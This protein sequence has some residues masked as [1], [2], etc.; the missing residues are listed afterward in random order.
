[1]RD[2]REAGRQ[3][4]SVGFRVKTLAQA[5][6]YGR[7]A[8]AV[9]ALEASCGVRDGR[10]TL[11]ECSCGVTGGVALVCR[12]T[13]NERPSVAGGSGEAML[14]RSPSLFRDRRN[15][16]LDL[17]SSGA[18]GATPASSGT[19]PPVASSAEG[20]PTA[21]DAPGAVEED[22]VVAW[23]LLPPRAPNHLRRGGVAASESVVVSSSMMRMAGTFVN[24]T[25]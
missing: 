22:P 2:R 16:H 14:G 8:A 6:C 19:S 9:S 17:D 5:I 7:S 12:T 18:A 24:G 10:T 13:T 21:V 1:M 25:A 15:V 11:K 3:G 4:A 23:L 20:A